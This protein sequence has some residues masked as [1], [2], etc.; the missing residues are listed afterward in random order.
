M[1]TNAGRLIATQS[2]SIL[3]S[4]ALIGTSA[5]WAAATPAGAADMTRFSP[6]S[7]LGYMAER[8]QGTS[9]KSLVLIEDLHVN[10]GVQKK[11]DGLLT[12]FSEKHVLPSFIAVEGAAGPVD[13]SLLANFPETQ[14]RR[15]AADYFMK[16]GELPGPAAFAVEQGLARELFGAE[17]GDY[18]ELNKALYH[19]SLDT[20]K[21]LAAQLAALDRPLKLMKQRH[22]SWA[23]RRLD[24][25]KIGRAHV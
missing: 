17:R 3:L 11:I 8:F 2:I 24:N 9:G 10:Y 19:K 25:V 18:Y 4:V 7:S 13:A 16:K 6:P 20:R 5:N 1:A 21:A 23:M 14:V 15:D 22:Y 12:Y